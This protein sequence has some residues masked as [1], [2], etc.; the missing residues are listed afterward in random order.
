M[1]KIVYINNIGEYLEEI[2]KINS[3]L[4]S[5]GFIKNEKML[6]R[7]QANKDYELI[8]SIGRNRQSK[9]QRSILDEE[10]NLI[11]LAKY[12]LPDVFKDSLKPLELLALLQHHGIPTRLLDVTESSLV[13]LYFACFDIKN[14]KNDG[15]VIVFIENQVDVASYPMYN[16][17]A[18][19]Y[20]INRNL[21]YIPL[22][23]F[24][25][26][27]RNNPYIIEQGIEVLSDVEGGE[28]IEK[29]CQKNLY[30][31]APSRSMRQITQK[32][33]YI[34]FPNVISEHSFDGNNKERVRKKCFNK[35]IKPIDKEKDTDIRKRII[36]PKEIKHQL[37][38]DLENSGITRELLFGDNID[39]V[40]EEITKICKK[41]NKGN[42]N[43]FDTGYFGNCDV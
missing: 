20:R 19:S 23:E 25:M 38:Q 13:A 15:E 2:N 40:C 39:I 11:E 10:R 36:I 22:D 14:K 17:I 29:I 4:I 3:T 7:G 6:F 1:D 16:A 34:L 27:I 24:F 21:S 33:R 43:R 8:P 12:K 37:L 5:D 26:K 31:F 42:D 30:V 28:W 41:R 18:D 32:G 9:N 35:L